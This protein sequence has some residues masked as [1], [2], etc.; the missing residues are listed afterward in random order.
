[1]MKHI[2]VILLGVMLSSSSAFAKCYSPKQAE[3][4]QGI[5]IHS[6]LMVIALNCQHL[7]PKDQKNLYVQYK[8]FTKENESIF[9]GYEKTLIKFYK[10]EGLSSPEKHLH[11]VRTA[12]ANKISKDAA[13]MRPDGFCKAYAPRVPKA[14]KM[15]KDAL[16]KW[17]SKVFPSHPVSHPVC[18]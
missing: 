12:F 6:E 7:W 10:S 2:I 3:A 11:E 13:V 18:N 15:N 1:M 4:E 17:A 16:H 9:A 8:E 14:A 5:R